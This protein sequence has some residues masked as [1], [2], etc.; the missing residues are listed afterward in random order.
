MYYDSWINVEISITCILFSFCAY[1]NCFLKDKSS[2]IRR[3]KISLPEQHQLLIKCDAPRH[4]GPLKNKW[5]ELWCMPNLQPHRSLNLFSAHAFK[6]QSL[7][8]TVRFIMKKLIHCNLF[9]LW[10]ALR[11]FPLFRSPELLR[12]PLAICFCPSSYVVSRSK[13]FEHF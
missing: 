1:V 3:L 8:P 6:N 10:P 4:F 5:S 13:T 2:L 7:C 11:N 12:W 9:K